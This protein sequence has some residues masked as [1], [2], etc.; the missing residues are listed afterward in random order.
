MHVH[1]QFLIIHNLNP[2]TEVVA[3]VEESITG[4]RTIRHSMCELLLS[5]G[6]K[7]RCSRCEAHRKSLLVMLKRHESTVTS[8]DPSSHTNYRYLNSEL[9]SE[10]CNNLHRSFVASQRKVTRMKEKIQ[11]LSTNHAISINDELNKDMKEI[12]K[13]NF[14]TIA[15][16]Y[17]EKTFERMFWEQHA[18]SSAR[19]DGRG[20]RWH[21][22]MIKWCL[23]LRHLSG[24]AY[25]TLRQSGVLKLPSQRTLRDYTHYIPTSIGYSAKLDQ[26]LMDTM[27][28]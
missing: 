7:S 13:E 15:A 9:L 6:K 8:T 11:Q 22:A 26:M 24:K 18:M 23:Y 2:G 5:P 21:P 27:K 20:F 14:T 17:P 1:Q 4:D 10:R 19:K 12:M 28:V 16:Q 3:K 25:E